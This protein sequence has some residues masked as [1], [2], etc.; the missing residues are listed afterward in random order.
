MCFQEGPYDL[1]IY[2]AGADPFEGDRLG[3]LKLTKI[4][5]EK[6]D[7]LV[8][9]SARERGIPVAIAMAGG[10]AHHLQDIVDIHANT[11]AIASELAK[12]SGTP[13]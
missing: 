6:R 3:R 1:M 10:Y 7:R 11:I 9:R 8:L 13:L 5:L 12:Q 2:L 4:G